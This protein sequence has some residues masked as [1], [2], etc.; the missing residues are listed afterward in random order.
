MKENTARSKVALLNCYFATCLMLALIA[1][2]SL[3]PT[4]SFADKVCLKVALSEKGKIVT[5]KQTVTD[6]KK[7]PKGFLDITDKSKLSASQKSNNSIDL[8]RCRYIY[9]NGYS[10]VYGYAVSQAFCNSD[11]EYLLNWSS[12]LTN[13]ESWCTVVR[14]SS[15]Y[16]SRADVIQGISIT[17]TWICDAY[18][19][20][21]YTLVAEAVCCRW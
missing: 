21:P 1:I 8:T 10:D 11:T 14:D 6:K 12:M 19:P 20:E 16:S 2:T 18:Y 13:N 9:S 15:F 4:P 7:C 5:T 17:S 3:C